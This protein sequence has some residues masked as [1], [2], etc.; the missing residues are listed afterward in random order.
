MSDRP[1]SVTGPGIGR[2]ESR[3]EIGEHRHIN[4]R[5]VK[6]HITSMVRRRDVHRRTELVRPASEAP[7][8]G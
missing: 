4:P 7:L 1:R 2:G 5:A 8:P 3:H 6:H